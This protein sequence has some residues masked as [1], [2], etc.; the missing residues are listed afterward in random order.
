M[1]PAARN[2]KIF[3]YRGNPHA[4]KKCMN[5]YNGV[6]CHRLNTCPL[7]S[8][9]MLF[10][11]RICFT[12]YTCML[13]CIASFLYDYTTI[14]LLVILLIKSHQLCIRNY[15][16]MKS[17]K[18]YIF[19]LIIVSINYVFTH[20]IFVLLCFTSFSFALYS[21]YGTLFF[22]SCS[23]FDYTGNFVSTMIPSRAPWDLISGVFITSDGVAYCFGLQ[24]AFWTCL[25]VFSTF[26]MG[27]WTHPCLF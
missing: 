1:P 19:T 10:V 16:L 12:A 26:S 11:K 23:H 22:L 14:M 20:P 6:S 18:A 8:F 3:Q 27:E 17:T 13:T 25:V 5:V 15:Y 24:S 4:W 21:F 2:N 9:I 7:H